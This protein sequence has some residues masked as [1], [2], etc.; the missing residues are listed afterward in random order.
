MAP[1][2]TS[3]RL[4]NRQLLS[5]SLKGGVLRAIG[6]TGVENVITVALN[7]N[8]T[9][10]DVSVNGTS[11]SYDLKKVRKLVVHGAELADSLTVSS[12]LKL[13]QHIFG[14]DGNDTLTGGSA[15]DEKAVKNGHR[16]GPRGWTK[17][18]G[19][20]GNDTLI[21]TGGRNFIDGG[22]G[23]D[24]ITGSDGRDLIAGFHGNDTID[25]KGGDDIVHGG[26][27]DDEIKLGAGH[28]KCLAGSGDDDVDGGEGSDRIFGQDG[29]D[30]LRGGAG[31]DFLFGQADADSL[32]G[33]DD[34]DSLFGGED[35]DV[36]DGGAGKNRLVQGDVDESDELE[37]EVETESV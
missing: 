16:H 34:D 2:A 3:E 27:G 33:G 31:R 37:D 14:Y 9:K 24:D 15:S 21:A 35:T 23:N 12:E 11:T 32:F 19:M 20:G 17:L 1:F 6:D 28:D 18:W 5:A 25:A 7:E 36:F 30:T 22:I 8:K 10:I 26:S 13:R 4:E 29:S